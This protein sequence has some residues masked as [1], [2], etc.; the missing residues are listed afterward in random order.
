MIRGDLREIDV[1]LAHKSNL[2]E[3]IAFRDEQ[4]ATAH[5][6]THNSPGFVIGGERIL[7]DESGVEKARICRQ[8]SPLHG[9]A[10]IGT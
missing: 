10:L 1:R 9:S 8:R 7:R 6:S 5:R 3:T 4:D 2:K